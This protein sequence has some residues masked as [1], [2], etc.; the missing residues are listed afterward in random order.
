MTLSRAT[1]RFLGLLGL[2]CAIALSAAAADDWC[3]PP[4]TG[5]GFDWIQR[6]SGEWLKGRIK[7]LTP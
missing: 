5:D 7:T 4:P 3:P 2:A 6:K 1:S